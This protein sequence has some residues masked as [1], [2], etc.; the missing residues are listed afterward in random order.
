MGVNAGLVGELV[1]VFGEPLLRDAERLVDRVVQIRRLEFALQVPGLVR[2]HDILGARHA[3]LDMH[4]RRDGAVLV[5]VALI[6]PH[7]ASRQPV[8]D[9]L[10]AGD[11]I[12]DHRLSVFGRVNIMKSDFGL[13]L[14]GCTPL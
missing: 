2:H 4:D 14:H 13:D 3:D 12:S 9:A 6:D 11:M 7:A 10:E 5:L 8:I 1:L